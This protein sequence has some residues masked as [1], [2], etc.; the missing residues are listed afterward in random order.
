MRILKLMLAVALVAALAPLTAVAIAALGGW[1]HRWADI[2]AQFTAPAW[3]AAALT[4]LA[5]LLLRVRLAVSGVA[6]IIAMLLLAAAWPQWA[7]T[8]GRGSPPAPEGPV[9]ARLYFANLWVRNQDLA[10]IAASIAEA[11]ADVVA[12]VELG[13]VPA[14]NLDLILPEHPHRLVGAPQVGPLGD[15]RLL[16]ASRRPIRGDAA[17]RDGLS[18]LSAVVPTAQGPV[19]VMVTHLTR[20]WPFTAQEAQLHQIKLLK[21]RL[22]DLPGPVVAAGDFNSVAT[23]RVGRTVRADNGLTHEPGFPG[24]WPAQAPAA[25]RMTID[26]AYVSDDLA[27]LRR[28]LGR[29]TGSD[30]S[31]IIVDL[32]HRRRSAG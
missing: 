1:D 24:T 19:R 23:A 22:D 6:A 15:A 9:S 27:I 4:T 2:L 20:P 21:A 28:R 11:D 25:L 29:P 16:I 10:A 31:P 17:P 3:A 32:A 26:H 5:L 30:H 18:A 14:A 8:Q 12:L 13:G 7:P